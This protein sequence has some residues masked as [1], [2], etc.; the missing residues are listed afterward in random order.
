MFVSEDIGRATARPLGKFH[1]K[2]IRVRRDKHLLL[3]LKF[4]NLQEIQLHR[5]LTPKHRDEHLYL[6]AVVVYF[7][8]LAFEILERPVGDLDDVVNGEVNGV[9]DFPGIH[10]AEEIFDFFFVERHRENAGA[11]EAGH[12]RR[13]AHDIP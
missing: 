6:A 4:L 8:H 7:A 1:Q 5:R 3:N 13:V 2:F 10:A 12:A 9:L 11:D